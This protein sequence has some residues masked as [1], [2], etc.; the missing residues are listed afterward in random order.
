MNNEK[1]KHAHQHCLVYEFLCIR[2]TCDYLVEV[3]YCVMFSSRVGIGIGLGLDLVSGWLVVMHIIVLL[4]AV[5]V[6][7]PELL[8]KK[9][10]KS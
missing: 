7:L 3:H 5:I 2:R 9:T 1:L 10:G 4:S 6:T 8:R